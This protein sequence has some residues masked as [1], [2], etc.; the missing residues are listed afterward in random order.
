MSGKCSEQPL[1][2]K[3]QYLQNSFM[4][5]AHESL[6]MQSQYLGRFAGKT[7]HW[8]VPTHVVTIASMF[9]SHVASHAGFVHLQPEGPIWNMLNI[10][11]GKEFPYNETYFVANASLHQQVPTLKAN[12]L[13]YLLLCLQPILTIIAFGETMFLYDTPLSQGFG[14]VSILAGVQR[15]SLDILAGATLSGE[16]ERPIR[17]SIDAS[18][19]GVSSPRVFYVVGGENKN[20]HVFHGKKYH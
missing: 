3:H 20:G 5:M 13:L 9:E 7:S 8:L 10:T 15:D 14:L 2:Y 16:L 17:L 4:T 11:F 19:K 12:K 6:S 1:A 18:G